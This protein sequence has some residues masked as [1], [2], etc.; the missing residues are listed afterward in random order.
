MNARTRTVAVAG[1]AC[2]AVAVPAAAQAK[3][4]TV[5][6]GLNKKQAKTIGKAVTN[7]KTDFID[8]N[9]FFPHGVTI[10]AGD[11]VKFVNTGAFHTVDIPAK[12]QGVLGLVAPDGKT[13]SGVNDAAGQ[14]FAFNGAPELGFNH[15]LLTPQFGKSVKYT[16]KKR[17]ESGLPFA[18]GDL[19]VRFTKAGRYRYFCDIHPH[20]SGRVTVRP[21]SKKIP[22]AKSDAART[23]NQFAAAVKEAKQVRHTQ[24][25]AN[26]VDVG[27]HGSRGVEYYQMFPSALTVHVGTTVNFRMMK[28]STEDHTATFGPADYLKPIEQSF[29]NPSPPDFA[30]DSRG[31]YQSEAPGTLASLTPLLHG[32]GFWNSGVMDQATAT[33]LPNN[34]SLRFDTPG[35]YHF[36]CVIHPNMHGTITVTP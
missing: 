34:N 31:V 19:T 9:D 32:N 7:A 5:D 29:S 6:M 25:P 22:S 24:A 11:K 36:F 1:L 15:A 35:T 14:P 20:M 10:H 33:P 16:G 17:V 28:G 23:K 4:K 8:V 13:V 21:K 26:V 12:G 30:L 2:L 18:R 27:A 3:T